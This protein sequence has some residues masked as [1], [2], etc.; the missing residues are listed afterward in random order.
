MSNEASKTTGHSG[1]NFFRASATDF[2]KIPGSPIAYW[3]SEQV[4]SAFIIGNI[5]SDIAEPR[6]GITTAD[7]DKYLRL[8]HEIEFSKFEVSVKAVV[9]IFE[10]DKKWFP[11]NKGGDYRK[12]YGNKE[13][14]ID[15][16]DN[17]NAL[18]NFEN[19]VIRNSA[20]Y[21]REGMTWNDISSGKFSMRYSSGDAMFEGKGPMAFA[22]NTNELKNLIAFF[23]SIVSA[24]M[25]SFL[26]PTLNFNIGEISKI[27]IVAEL[28][29]LP[30]P[31]RN[32]TNCI[33]ISRSDWDSYE[34]SWDF[35]ENPLIRQKQPTPLVP[36]IPASMPE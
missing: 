18:K 13:V 32:S 31:E 9:G 19:S 35:T 11:V 34:T 12:W 20:Y 21:F 7:N 16:F 27:P 17:G 29:T 15:W 33:S 24:S 4:R 8:W 26:C 36:V 28:L 2:K 23:N 25:L 5:L 6:K 1:R 3:V 22:Q 10:S 30:I 14:V